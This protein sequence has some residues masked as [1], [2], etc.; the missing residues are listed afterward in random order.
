MVQYYI[1][2]PANSVAG[3]RSNTVETNPP[4]GGVN[5]PWTVVNND[6]CAYDYVLNS[7]LISV[8]W[9]PVPVGVPISYLPTILAGPNAGTNPTITCT[10]IHDI[11]SVVLVT[12]TKP[13]AGALFM[14]ISCFCN[15]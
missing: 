3:A 11:F 12:G 7:D 8:T 5:V 6:Y 15:H 14:V 2:Y 4:V 1:V 13:V 9:S 10:G